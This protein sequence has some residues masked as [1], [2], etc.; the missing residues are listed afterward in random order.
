MNAADI[1]ALAALVWLIVRLE[2]LRSEN[3]TAH[4]RIAWSIDGLKQDLT[5][6]I[7]GLKQD[8]TRHMDGIRHDPCYVKQDVQELPTGYVA[9]MPAVL[10][11]RRR[12][13]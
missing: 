5:K 2:R 11:G 7:D 10:Q 6:S 1:G 8:L 3:N 4:D 9:C 13:D 12:R